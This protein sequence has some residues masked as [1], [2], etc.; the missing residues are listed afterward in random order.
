MLELLVG[1]A[2]QRLERGLVAEPVLAADLQHLGRDEALDQAEHVGVG[3]ALDLAQQTLLVAAEKLERAHV[4]QAVGQEFMREIELAPANHVALDVQ[5]HALG[6]L[7]AA[8]VALRTY[9]ACD[10][11]FH[12]NLPMVSG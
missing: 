3:A 6:D 1:E 5:A 7:D 8:G 11:H 4:R 9:L 10:C 12:L 2:H